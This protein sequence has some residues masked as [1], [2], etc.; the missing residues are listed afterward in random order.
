MLRRFNEPQAPKKCSAEAETQFAHKFSLWA[1]NPKPAHDRASVGRRKHR[2][3]SGQR[4]VS[5]SGFLGPISSLR[6]REGDLGS[7]RTAPVPWP[8]PS[9]R[10]SLWKSRLKLPAAARRPGLP[11]G[12]SHACNQR[13]RKEVV[14]EVSRKTLSFYGGD[15]GYSLMS[16]TTTPDQ[17]LFAEL[18]VTKGNRGLSF[19]HLLFFFSLP[20]PKQNGVK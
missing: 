7:L 12:G 13:T 8:G 2:R 14:G 5:Q 17:I 9:T 10:A 1:W 11:K 3:L 15:G 18:S 19:S 6:C 20:F 4:T 16:S